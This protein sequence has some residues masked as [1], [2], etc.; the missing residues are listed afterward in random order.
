MQV[1]KSPSVGRDMP[2]DDFTTL[3]PGRATSG[4]LHAIGLEVE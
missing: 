1:K 3:D 4:D 2:L